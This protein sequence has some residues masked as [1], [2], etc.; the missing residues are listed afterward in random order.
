MVALIIIAIL[1]K[2]FMKDGEIQ[3]HALSHINSKITD[4]IIDK[5][6]K[7]NL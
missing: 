4:K 5:S 2:V 3:H 6:I 7:D 1:L